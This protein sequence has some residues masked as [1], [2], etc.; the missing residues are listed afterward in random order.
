[1]S[2]AFDGLLKDEV[3]VL[4]TNKESF[5]VLMERYGITNDNVEDKQSFF[6]SINDTCGTDEVPFFKTNKSNVMVLFFDD[7][8]EDL[9]IPTQEVKKA[10]AFTLEQAK[11]LFAF[12][13]KNKHRKTC[14]V[15]CAAGISRSGAVGTFIND[16]LGGNYSQFK[17]RNPYIHPNGLVL[18]LLKKVCREAGEFSVIPMDEIYDDV[19][20]VA[21]VWVENYEPCGMDLP[22][23]H[24]LASDIQTLIRNHSDK[25]ISDVINRLTSMRPTYNLPEFDK[26]KSNDSVYCVEWGMEKQKMIEQAIYDKYITELKLK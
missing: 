11:E 19:R 16:Y 14:I 5:D 7:V 23:K 9:T 26:S 13:E 12:V 21:A 24:K 4:V 10:K 3:N 15:H 25:I 22:N 8:E 6:I 18:G 1:M 20:K 2:K 17:K